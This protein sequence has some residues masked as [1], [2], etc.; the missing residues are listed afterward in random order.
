M[1]GLATKSLNHHKAIQP[2][3]LIMGAGICLIAGALVRTAIMSPEVNWSK[4]KDPA[5]SRHLGYYE[6]RRFKLL[7]PKAVDYED[8]PDKRKAPK[9]MEE[10]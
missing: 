4:S 6:N 1:Q 7:D 5:D 2:L 8:L 10:E 3:F 9:Y